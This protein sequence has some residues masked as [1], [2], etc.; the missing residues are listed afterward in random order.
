MSFYEFQKYSNFRLKSV[1]VRL[2]FYQKLPVCGKT[3]RNSVFL[4]VD[5]HIPEQLYMM[6]PYMSFCGFKKIQIFAQNTYVVT[7]G[8][9]ENL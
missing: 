9:I 4:G 8:F 7:Y 3:D 5:H 6:V 1:G 2:R